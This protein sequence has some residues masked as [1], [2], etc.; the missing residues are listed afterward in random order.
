MTKS[1]TEV[2]SAKKHFFWFIVSGSSVCYAIDSGLMMRL[3]NVTNGR[4]CG[5]QGLGKIH[6]ARV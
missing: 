2:A 1:L 3:N 6:I 5:R 4:A